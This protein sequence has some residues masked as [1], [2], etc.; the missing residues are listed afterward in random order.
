M[1]WNPSAE[2]I[3]GCCRRIDRRI[4]LHAGARRPRHRAHGRH[5][6]GAP[7]GQ[8]FHATMSNRTNRGEVIHTEWYNTPLVDNENKIIGVASLVQD[9]TERFNTE[10]TIHYM[11]H[12]DALT[13]LP[14]RRPMQGPLEPGDPSGAPASKSARCADVPDRPFS[15]FRERHAGSRRVTTCLRD[16]AKVLP[17]P[18]GR[19]IPFRVKAGD[20]HHR[21]AGTESPSP[22]NR[23]PTR[24]STNWLNRIEVSGHDYGNS[25]H[26]HLTLPERR[27]RHPAIVETCRFGNVPSQGCRPQYPHVSSPAI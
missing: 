2:A 27:H 5:V 20:V 6:D 25:L 10:R 21:T 13:G 14:N 7:T 15:S 8:G 12:H 24:F 23:S 19:A 18:C 9:I 11:A 16:I 26:R 4:R 1:T 17:K 22:R 3:F